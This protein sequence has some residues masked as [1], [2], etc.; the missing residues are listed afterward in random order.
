MSAPLGAPSRLAV[1]AT[2]ALA[3]IGFAANSILCRLA[4]RF[5]RIDPAGFTA[6]RLA[7]GTIA[8]WGLVFL[9]GRSSR[10]SRRAG[11][12]RLSGGSRRS[13]RAAASPSGSS[14]ISGLLLFAYAFAFSLAYRSLSVG[15]GALI[16]FGAVQVT[17]IAA[18]LLSGER[19]HWLQWVGLAAA[20]AGLLYLV[21]P[22]ISA[23]PLGG[24]VLMAIAGHAWGIY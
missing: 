2:G 3:M 10:G 22:G 1:L 8:L 24:A 7:S 12:S 18:G 11:G 4:L 14:W 9:F 21:S 20:T 19:P 16:L 13:S 23:P 15:T 6:V 17:M 5:D